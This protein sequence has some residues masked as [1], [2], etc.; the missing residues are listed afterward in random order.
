MSHASHPTNEIIMAPPQDNREAYLSWMARNLVPPLPQETRTVL[1]A[2]RAR[3]NAQGHRYTFKV[4]FM[5]F[6]DDFDRSALSAGNGRDKS[7]T[8]TKGAATGGAATEGAAT[9]T[10]TTMGAAKKRPSA[11]LFPEPLCLPPPVKPFDEPSDKP[12]VVPE[13]LQEPETTAAEATASAIYRLLMGSSEDIIGLGCESGCGGHRGD[14]YL[15]V[16]ATYSFSHVEAVAPYLLQ[17]VIPVFE[18][19]SNVPLVLDVCIRDP[20]S[21]AYTQEMHR[22]MELVSTTVSQGNPKAH[23]VLHWAPLLKKD[24]DFVS[25]NLGKWSKALEPGCGVTVL[26]HR[27]EKSEEVNLWTLYSAERENAVQASKEL[28]HW[29]RKEHATHLEWVQQERARLAEDRQDGK[30]EQVQK[31]KKKGGPKDKG[32][33]EIKGRKI[34]VQDIDN[35][36]QR[37]PD[38][39]AQDQLQLQLPGA[40]WHIPTPACMTKDIG[41]VDG[42]NPSDGACFLHLGDELASLGPMDLFHAVGF[43]PIPHNVVNKEER[44]QYRIWN[45]EVLK[46]RNQS[47]GDANTLMFDPKRTGYYSRL[48]K[49][50]SRSIFGRQGILSREWLVPMTGLLHNDLVQRGLLLGPMMPPGTRGSDSFPLY[51]EPVKKKRVRAKKSKGEPSPIRRCPPGPCPVGPCSPEPGLE[52]PLC[53]PVQ[54]E[55]ED[56]DGKEDSEDSDSYISGWSTPPRKYISHP[57]TT[58]TTQTVTTCNETLAASLPCLGGSKSSGKR[59]REEE[60][61]IIERVK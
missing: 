61:I 22:C 51:Q 17:H 32:Q 40:V 59:K 35:Q 54:A 10:Q 14:A 46:V 29:L 16:T 25:V 12:T 57:N 5:L 45:D 6:D 9:T 36:A 8:D 27:P 50:N 4:C 48:L 43:E 7:T 15:Y 30:G 39:L 21:D 55:N 38:T 33:G 1:D 41:R 53:I 18:P 26:M 58:I 37:T 13:P 11:T 23:I 42:T 56:D 34:Q 47:T 19:R 44:I 49:S 31:G 20:F 2:N 3:C 52:K 60:L 24:L 28:V